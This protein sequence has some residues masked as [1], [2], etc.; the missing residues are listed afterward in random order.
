MSITAT[1]AMATAMS[2]TVDVD[3]SSTTA[4]TARPARMGVATP[5]VAATVASRR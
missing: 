5:R 3:R 4:S 2:T 1:T